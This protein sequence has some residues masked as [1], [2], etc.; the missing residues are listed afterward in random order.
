M[1][2]PFKLT[3][4]LRLATQLLTLTTNKRHRIM[5]VSAAELDVFFFT[6][7]SSVATQD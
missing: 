3:S 1:E 2:I 5:L 7:T 6:I 4:N